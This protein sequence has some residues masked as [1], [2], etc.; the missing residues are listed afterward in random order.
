MLYAT[1]LL[2]GLSE[3]LQRLQ[4][5]RVTHSHNVPHLFIEHIY[6]YT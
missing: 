2:H 1:Y 4:Q 6:T 3:E 5:L